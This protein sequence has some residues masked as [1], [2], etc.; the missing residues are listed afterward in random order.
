MNSS[1]MPTQAKFRA[2]ME[3]WLTDFVEKPSAALNGWAPCPYARKARVKNSIG[4]LAVEPQVFESTVEEQ[5]RHFSDQHEVLVIG[6]IPQGH[7]PEQIH[8]FSKRMREAYWSQDIWV[9]FDHPEDVE[10]INGLRMNNG[11]YLLAMIQRLSK[12]TRA[13]DQLEAEGYYKSWPDEEKRAMTEERKKKSQSL[14]KPKA[15][16]TI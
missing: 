14:A 3:K 6:T 5:I 15:S 8:E 7:S 1:Q 16:I 4:Y 2:D 12:L 11:V 10:E 9:L 13:S